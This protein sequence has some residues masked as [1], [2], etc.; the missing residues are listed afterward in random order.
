MS[1][2]NK[3][4]GDL[5]EKKE[6]RKVEARAKALPAEYAAAYKEVKKYIFHTSG[7]ETME[8]LRALVDMLEEAAASNRRVLE[9]IGPNVAAFADELVRGEKSYFE[10]QR[11]KLNKDIAK[12]FK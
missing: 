4:T 5:N 3:I 7:I 8:P 10:Q 9:I 11:K 2:L 1:I 6:W 12:K